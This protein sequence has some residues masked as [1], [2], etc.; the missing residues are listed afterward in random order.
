MTGVGN[1]CVSVFM[2]AEA[3]ARSSSLVRARLLGPSSPSAISWYL[4]LLLLGAS[5]K[6]STAGKTCWCA[7]SALR[8]PRAS[9]VSETRSDQGPA[10]TPFT[11]APGSVTAVKSEVATYLEMCSRLTLSEW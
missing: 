8:T 11:L 2:A 3:L 1:S 10:G 5:E 7:S 9:S 4:R 6:T